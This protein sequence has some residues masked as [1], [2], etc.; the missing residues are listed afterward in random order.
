MSR[1]L[2][3]T[4]GIRGKAGEYPL[5]AAGAQQVGKAIAA[6][7]TKPGEL[8]VVGSDPRESSPALT[9]AVINGLLT[10]GVQVENVG[11]IPTPGLAYLTKQRGAAVGVMITASHNP[12]TD[13]GIKVFAAGGSKLTDAIEISLNNLI[14]S[15]IT[16][17]SP[18]Q[19]AASETAVRAYE[20]FLI[21]C[22]EGTPLEGFSIALD[23]ANGATS[24]I[25][26]RVFEKLGAQVVPL[27]DH[28]NGTNI[29]VACGATDT[30]TV[31]QVVREQNLTA[32]AAFDGDGD[33]VMLVDEK[34]RLLSGDHLLYILA[35]TGHHTGVVTT[36]MSNMGLETALQDH[37]ISLLRTAV[38]DRYVL[39]GLAQTGFSLGG[40][41]SGHIILSQYAGT[42]DGLLAAILVCKQVQ[43]SGKTLAQW[44]DELPLLPQALVNV[45]LEDKKLLEDP[46][47][48]AFIEAQAARLGNNGRLNI[49][50]SG[51]EPKLRI[52]VE[53]TDA[54]E[55]AEDIADQLTGIINSLEKQTPVNDKLTLIAADKTLQPLITYLAIGDDHELE[56]QL[57]AKSRQPNIL[58]FTPNDAKKRFGDQTMLD[59]WRAKGREIHWLLGKNNDLAGIIWYG[60]SQFPLDIALPEIPEETF[61]IRI[62]D[63]YAGH[64][65]A[66]S[67]LRLSLEAHVH[68][69]QSRGEA[70]SGIWGQTDIDNPAALAVYVKFGYQEVDRDSKRVTLV[71]SSEQIKSLLQG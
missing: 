25:A 5:D 8:I 21:N 69:K 13:N 45:P 41:Q 36:L 29:N 35:V 32:G 54:S 4:D 52:M 12:Y 57:I 1:K 44:Y 34:G 39:E 3:G 71:L 53:A 18:G 40:E 48:S 20:T 7:F 10:M 58:K 65:L 6:Y 19:V 33:R 42:G 2:F 49:R 63:G 47:V 68:S 30:T 66:R 46:K 11:V 64:G 60:K 16:D 51:T 55:L 67:A 70:V 37:G 22:A 17:R 15:E 61:A 50:P 14:D 9:Q 24:G 31:Q 43:A 38:G 56:Q 62:Y 26:L 59:A 27:F 23:S 28:P